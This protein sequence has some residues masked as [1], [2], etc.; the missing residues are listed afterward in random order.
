MDCVESL[1]G[2]WLT[3]ILDEPTYNPNHADTVDTKNTQ[4]QWR[5]LRREGGG[6]GRGE[7]KERVT[8]KKKKKKK[9]KE[10]EREFGG[11]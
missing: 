8:K 1:N 9:K 7:E 6:G 5:G 2:L 4:Y 3:E 10:K 11:R